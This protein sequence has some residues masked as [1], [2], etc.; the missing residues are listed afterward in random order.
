MSD[1]YLSSVIGDINEVVRQHGNK[2]LIAAGVGSGK[3][4]WVKNVLSKQ[5]R[6]LFITSRRAKVDEDVRDSRFVRIDSMSLTENQYITTNAGIE[7]LLK[8]YYL[9]RIDVSEFLGLFNY[10]VVD[11]I[12]SIAVDS[13][14][15][16]SS[17]ALN[18]FILYA[19]SQGK[20]VIGMTGTPEPMLSYLDY[21]D[22]HLIDLR[23]K[24]RYVHPDRITLV[25]KS[26]V[27]EM[28][29]QCIRRNRR[30]VY[31]ANMRGEIPELIQSIVHEKILRESQI[32]VIVGTGARQLLQDDLK[33]VLKGKAEK[34]QAQSIA[35]YRFI[36]EK[37]K[38]PDS[39][40]LLI[41]TS[42]LREGVDIQ[43]DDC[44]IICENHIL[45]NIIQYFGRV[46]I[47]GGTAHIVTNAKQHRVD[48]YAMAFHYAK[49]SETNNLN[50]YLR[51][52]RTNS[53][54]S[55][56]E[57]YT[58]ERDGLLQ[59]NM[60]PEDILKFAE[61][62]EAGNDYI[63]FDYINARFYYFDIKY[64]EERR[65][66]SKLQSSANGDPV[67]ISDL[68]EYCIKYGIKL[69]NIVGNRE[70]EERQ[71]LIDELEEFVVSNTRFYKDCR[72]HERIISL[73]HSTLG[74]TFRGIS[75]L[76]NQLIA[77]GIPY[78]IVNERGTGGSDRNRTWWTIVRAD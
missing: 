75:S 73:M 38:I 10:I 6:V 22:W 31:F 60:R 52:I 33:E 29:R 40:C 64:R 78:L 11:E 2:I 37:K 7:N 35:A 68:R 76:N 1:R 47:G 8:Q 62:I 69:D 51:E 65:I 5:G 18:A 70:A 12:H 44:E 3:T 63:Y 61:F 19:V 46:R 30:V 17:F 53:R 72:E 56:D 4:Y 58:L 20:V 54:Y 77:E 49:H 41:C 32:A 74:G 28:I 16:R 26:D 39:C 14:F 36:T 27:T 24:C 9:N 57:D 42:A 21:H 71:R 45:T 15:A 13:S 67:W 48:Q 43:N 50:N 34:I 59:R 55:Q 66:I 23:E 25:N